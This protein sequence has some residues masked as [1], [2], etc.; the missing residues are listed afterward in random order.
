MTFDRWI[1]TA[2]HEGIDRELALNILKGAKDPENGL[3]L[4]HAA[5]RI[6]D[7]KV[8][9]DLY[10]SSGIGGVLPCQIVPRCRYCNYRITDALDDEKLVMA[11]KAIENLGIRQVHLS[12]GTSLAGY[13]K[14][15]LAMVMAIK[16]AS[17]IDLEVNL[18][19]SLSLETVRTLK[20]LGV[21][22]I[23]SSLETYSE[24]VFA[25]AKPGDSLSRR[26]ALVEMCDQEGI[27]IRS[28]MLIGLGETLEDRIDG[29]FYL[30]QF[31]NLYHLRFS[32][33]FPTPET[34]YSTR[35]RCSP[36]DYVTTVAVARLILPD[37]Q[38]GMAAGNSADDIPLWYAAGGGNQL[39]G[40]HVNR[41]SGRAGTGEELIR[42]TDD[43]SVVNRIPTLRKYVEGMGRKLRFEVTR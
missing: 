6:R 20:S 41:G 22:S 19:P 36:W 34:P 11:V 28:M 16:A 2:V 8:G 17:D 33:F 24:A 13:D 3:R 27:S 29:L 30:K 35:D 4:F 26:K 32:R 39:L 1:E 42:V 40:A 12:G 21:S 7:E 9:K 18:G 14:E 15:I 23:T 10:L 38:L 5:T 37:V 25:D 43:V 31:S